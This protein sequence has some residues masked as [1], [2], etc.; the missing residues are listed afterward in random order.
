MTPSKIW[1]GIGAFALAAMGAVSVNPSNR[2]LSLRD[3]S[4]G[5]T[6][7][8]AQQAPAPAPD[9]DDDGPDDD[10]P[11]DGKDDD[12]PDDGKDDDGPDDGKDDDG[13]DDGT[14]ADTGPPAKGK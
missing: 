9:K 7:A 12:G 6:S 5:G 10:G 11:D 13:P 14:P 3:V 1:I 4:F 2:D 8:L